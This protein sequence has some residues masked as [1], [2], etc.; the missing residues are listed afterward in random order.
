MQDV[1][2]T[3]ALIVGSCL[4][5]QAVNQVVILMNVRSKCVEG[6]TKLVTEKTITKEEAIL[7][8]N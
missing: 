4:I 6:I 3:T 1:H 2:K 7:L 5:L 8:V